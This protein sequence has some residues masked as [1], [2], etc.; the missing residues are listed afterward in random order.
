MFSTCSE[1]YYVGHL[2]ITLC[3]SRIFCFFHPFLLNDLVYSRTEKAPADNSAE[4]LHTKNEGRPHYL[5]IKPGSLLCMLRLDTPRFVCI[6]P[7]EFLQRTNTG[8]RG[9]HGFLQLQ[10]IRVR[11]MVLSS[12]GFLTIYL[13][14]HEE[15]HSF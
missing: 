7:N 1:H 14:Q 13:R 9:N 4:T 8:L 11:Q 3:N 5:G 6:L 15:A 2:L 10:R 12:V